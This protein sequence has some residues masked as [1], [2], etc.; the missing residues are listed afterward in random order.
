MPEPR[1]TLQNSAPLSN[2]MTIDFMNWRN[3][4]SKTM[5]VAL[6]TLVLYR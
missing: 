3:V 2:S 4:I 6:K 5:I 1:S